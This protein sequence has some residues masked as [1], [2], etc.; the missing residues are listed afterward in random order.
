V[1]IGPR[2]FSIG[3]TLFSVRDLEL[4]NPCTVL[5]YES[6][7]GYVLVRFADGIPRAL[8]V[9]SLQR[10]WDRKDE[11]RPPSKDWADAVNLGDYLSRIE[12]GISQ[13]S[14]K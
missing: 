7:R 4:S 11:P 13:R 9:A 14:N 10:A 5:G 6:E 8:P 3:E 12:S 2:P 1:K